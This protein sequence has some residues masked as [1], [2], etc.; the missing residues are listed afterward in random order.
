[1]SEKLYIRLVCAV[2]IARL[3]PRQ[4]AK[5]LFYPSL[6]ASVLPSKRWTEPTAKQQYGLSLHERALKR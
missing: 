3:Q 5:F 6:G 4:V 2:R 1:M